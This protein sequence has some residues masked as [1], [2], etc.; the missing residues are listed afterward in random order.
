MSFPSKKLTKHAVFFLILN[1][2]LP[3]LFFIF[4]YYKPIMMKQESKLEICWRELHKKFTVSL[5]A[6]FSS[7]DINGWLSH[8]AKKQTINVY[9]YEDMG[10][11]IEEVKPIS[12]AT[13]KGILSPNLPDRVNYINAEAI[14]K[15]LGFNVE[16]RYS[17]VE[18]NYNN[19][20]SLK[21]IQKYIE[22]SHFQHT[23][24][25]EEGVSDKIN[26]LTNKSEILK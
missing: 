8:F 23:F 2:Y 21:S 3:F 25:S 15:E 24:S 22:K 19:L 26:I 14:A 9:Q 13:L 12:L 17:N 7:L 11:K 20:I 10:G 5:E 6:H 16:V 18:S 4:E 1:K